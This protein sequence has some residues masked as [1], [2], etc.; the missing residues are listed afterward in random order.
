MMRLLLLASVATLLLLGP[1]R[2]E[3]PEPTLTP[4]HK[5][6]DLNV[7]DSQDVELADGKKVRVKLLDLQETRDPLRKAVRAAQLKLEVGGETVTLASGN[8]HLPTTVG[9]VQIDCAVTRGYRQDNAK[10]VG[11]EDPWGLEKDARLRLWPAG[12]PWIKPG[13]FR[14][15]ARQRWFAS[16]TQM[17]NEPVHV[18]GGENP[19]VKRIYYHYGLDIG[20]AEAMVDVIAATDGTVVSS[21]KAILPGYEQTPAKPRYDVV[22]VLDGRGWFYRYSHLHT[23]SPDVTPGAKVKIGQRIG[24]LGKEGGSGG[25]SHLHFDISGK[26]PSGKWGII[27]GYAFI[28]EAYRNEHKPTLLAV[29]RPHHLV[30]VGEKVMLDGS[31]S[32]A[33]SGK[34][35]AY[36]WTFGDGKTADGPRAERVYEKPGVYSEVLKVTDGAGRVDYDFAVVNVVDRD[37]PDQLPPSIHAVYS[38][39]FGIK[40]GDPVTFLVRTFRTTDGKE[41]WDFGDGTPTVEVQ[42][43]GNVVALAKDGYARTVHKYEKP[44]HY[45][46]KVSRTNRRG[47]TATARLQVR[48]GNDSSSAAPSAERLDVLTTADS[49]VPPSRMLRAYLLREAQKHF[50]ARRTV[51]EG[52]KTPEAI[53]ARQRELRA[54]FIES[55]GGFPEKTPLNAK[56]VAKEE[57]DGYRIEKV[58]YESRPNHHITA[59]L[60][61]PGRKPPFPGVLMPI[62]HSNNGKAAEYIQRGAILLAKNGIAVLTYDPI[63]QGERRQ[64]LDDR[65]QPVLKGSTSEH[66]MIG[67]G[68]LLVGRS[69]ASY[70]I[71]DG[72]RSLDY[73]ASRPE[74]DPERL[75]CTGCSGGG[76]MTSYLMALDDR[77]AVAAPSC[78]LTSLER[79]FATIGPQDA[80]QNITGQVAF[81]MEHADYLTMRTPRPTL[82]CAATRDFFDIQGTWTT[83]RESKRIYGL[84]GH[85][86]RVDLFESDS[87][88]GFPKSQ[89]E[90]TARWMR[91]W[92]LRIDDAVVEEKF[93]I[94]KDADVQCTRTGQVLEEFKGKS[95]FALNAEREMELARGRE[96]T[97]PTD[98]LVKDIRRLTALKAPIAPA[99][100][101]EVGT[102]RRGDLQIQK[103]VFET[104]P[105]IRL[106]ALLFSRGDTKQTSVVIYVNGRGKAEEAGRD[107]SIEKLVASGVRVLALDLRG[108]GE[109]APGKGG[110]PNYF[111]ADFNEAYIALHLNRPLLGQ[112]LYDLLAVAKKMGEDADELRLVG[113]GEAGPIA[114]HAALLEPRFKE[115]TLERSLISWLAVVRTP[116]TVN[117]LTNVVPGVLSAYDLPNLAAA[118]APRQLR[119]LEPLSPA[120]EPVSQKVLD[121]A[122]RSAREAYT[123][124]EA[125][126]SL[127]LKAASK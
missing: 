82:I 59:T 85:G 124:K 37:H 33:A 51:I 88:H 32:W 26:Q 106:P 62:G 97:P 52:L 123:R 100:M 18:D 40:A 92:L 125:A 27:E 122:Y 98:S 84:M 53:A 78:Y 9:G 35:A 105:G 17:A 70:R 28:W 6:I 115:V 24:L 61:L 44:G 77:I 79:L 113:T 56:V 93:A 94:A 23:I 2:A 22:Y 41:T 48:V 65:G 11:G 104:E 127:S 116:V 21:G 74:I 91:R 72:I 111:G 14:Y 25:W 90:A 110:K 38:P 60:Y 55:I 16:G 42:S 87:T 64:L 119:V 1:A 47:E 109:T 57:R 96:Q 3:L 103:L 86:E 95:A 126:E 102:L 68:A 114:L 81:G 50:D 49:D 63:G 31:R 54:R 112:R 13:T 46:V 107:G 121:E 99:V 19:L 66:T 43:D 118:L 29:A 10:N 39:T 117:Q 71:W 5:T 58:I 89:R 108:M 45:L 7:G 83:F 12:S 75:G 76:T 36:A 8:Y 67:V 101:K 69:T 20:G 15:P 30:S 4:I 120:G 34:I 73:L 80:E